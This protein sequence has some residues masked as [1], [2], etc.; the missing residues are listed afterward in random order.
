MERTERVSGWGV[1]ATIGLA[2]HLGSW[3]LASGVLQSRVSKIPQA[4]KN[5]RHSRHSY[6]WV[7]GVRSFLAYPS[8]SRIQIPTL[9]NIYTPNQELG[10]SIQ[11]RVRF[12]WCSLGLGAQ[13]TT[14]R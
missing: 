10:P 5:L 2:L 1:S 9:L 11:R 7:S 6:S 8:P 14:G 3:A 12:L 13:A 4:V